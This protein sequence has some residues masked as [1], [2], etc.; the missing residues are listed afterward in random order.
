[1][2]FV[3]FLLARS[4]MPRLQAPAPDQHTLNTMLQAAA[5]VPD[6][7]GLKPW[8]FIVCEGLGLKRLG[9]IFEQAA[10]DNDLS[11][12]DIARAPELPLRAPMVVVITTRL[13]EHP[14]VPAS[15]QFSAASCAVYAM[16]LAARAKGFDSIW[17]TGPYAHF[18]QVKQA[19]GVAESEHIV[20]FLY[21]GTAQGDSPQRSR[22]VTLPTYEQWR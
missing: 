8:H 4:S 5:S 12:R 20:G 6:H 19:L 16:Q 13:T 17:R 18:D 22:E 3:D 21:V 14:K 15:E 9:D 10:I 11:E 2:D 1:M 7:A